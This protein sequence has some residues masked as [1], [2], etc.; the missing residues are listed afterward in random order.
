[1][2]L[3]TFEWLKIYRD[4]TTIII[5]SLILLLFSVPFIIGIQPNSDIELTLLEQNYEIGEEAIADLAD[6]PAATQAVENIKERNTYLKG[7]IDNLKVGNQKEALINERN[8]ERLN[9]QS[10]ADGSFSRSSLQEQTKIVRVLEFL[11]ASHIPKKESDPREMGAINYIEMIF[12]TPNFV[13]I[14][15]LLLAVY[16][17]YF[18]TLDSRT[19]TSE[20]YQAAPY[21]LFHIYFQKVTALGISIIINIGAIILIVGG[22]L[23]I[24]NGVG[25]TAYPIAILAGEEVVIISTVA[26]LFQNILFLASWLLYLLLVGLFVSLF[27]SNLILNV[28]VLL[29]PLLLNQYNV[30]NSAVSDQLKPYL[31]SNY[32]D[33][34]RIIYGG[35]DY[36][37][38][39]SADLTVARGITLLTAISLSIFIAT[40]IIIR[41]KNKFNRL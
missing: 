41:N 19:K 6:E 36:L 1:M 31:I 7:M 17:A 38:L 13:I 28:F 37:P 27:T 8:L 16:I 22:I 39:P 25:Y 35:S 15:L 40:I 11:V 14:L 30:L 29:L 18:L 10:I 20:V 9:L 26:Y 12:S 24:K 21:S 32:A 23:A 34:S 4:R 3:W 33:V 5:F 2:K